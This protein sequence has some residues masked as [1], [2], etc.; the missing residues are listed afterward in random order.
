ML[1]AALFT[2]ALFLTCCCGGS[3]GDGAWRTLAPKI[4]DLRQE[5]AAIV[6]PCLSLQPVAGYFVAIIH[7][8]VVSCKQRKHKKMC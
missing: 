3:P 4:E 8:Q 7:L 6:Y 5:D 1:E 2:F